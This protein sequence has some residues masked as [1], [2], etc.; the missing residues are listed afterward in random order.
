MNIDIVSFCL[1]LPVIGILLLFI[2]SWWNIHYELEGVFE[3]YQTNPESRF[4]N[5]DGLISD[6]HGRVCAWAEGW[7]ANHGRYWGEGVYTEEL[8]DLIPF[9]INEKMRRQISLF[10]GQKL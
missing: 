5:E 10:Y 4:V 7:R 1:I 8:R 2:K 6:R 9:R 3:M